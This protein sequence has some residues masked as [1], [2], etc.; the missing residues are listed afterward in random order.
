MLSTVTGTADT[1]VVAA[2]AVPGNPSVLS[3]GSGDLTAAAASGLTT[4][5]VAGTTVVCADASAFNGAGLVVGDPSA[6]SGGAGSGDSGMTIVVSAGTLIFGPTAA[7]TTNVALTAPANFLSS[8][9]LSAVTATGSFTD[10]GGLQSVAVVTPNSQITD[11]DGNPITITQVTT[12]YDENGAMLFTSTVEQPASGEP[13]TLTQVYTTTTDPTGATTTTVSAATDLTYSLATG[14]SAQVD[15]EA[16][17]V[18]TTADS[19]GVVT[20]QNWSLNG[21]P[22]LAYTAAGD[23]SSAS[24]TDGSGGVIWTKTG[25]DAPVVPDDP[26]G[27]GDSD[28]GAVPL[29]QDVVAVT[30]TATFSPTVATKATGATTTITP[31]PAGTNQT[32]VTTVVTPPSALNPLAAVANSNQD[33]ATIPPSPPVIGGQVSVSVTAPNN[34]PNTLVTADIRVLVVDTVL[35][36]SNPPDPST[37]GNVLCAITTPPGAAS[38]VAGVPTITVSGTTG[39]PTGGNKAVRVS[40]QVITVTGTTDATGV[41]K[42]AIVI[43]PTV[44]SQVG[45]T[46]T[47]TIFVSQ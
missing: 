10:P 23:G 39:F 41:F 25:A 7:T 15:S 11:A 21:A 45:C 29:G 34:A 30:G 35:A 31:G 42:N 14:Y 13:T 33:P 1:A 38:G 43:T 6:F 46:C 12:G 28:S 5:Q 18:T 9:L 3:I 22:S 27:S 44:V 40:D 37:Q 2:P 32:T 16:P 19:S 17:T 4:F 26:S 20:Q 47:C 24:L 8:S 36:A